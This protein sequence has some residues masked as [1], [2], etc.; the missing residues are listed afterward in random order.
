MITIDGTGLVTG[1][2]G[3]HGLR[4]PGSVVQTLSTTKTDAFSTNSTSFV[5]ITGLSVDITP[6]STSS[7]VL[8]QFVIACGND[9]ATQNRFEL[10]RQVGGSDTS[11]N[12][13]EMDSSTAMFYVDADGSNETYTRAQVAYNFLDSPSTTGQ[14]NYRLRTKIYSSSV[15]QYVNRAAYNSNTIGSSTITVMEIAA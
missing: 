7:K 14:V 5:D 3:G 11:I 15:T 6:T 13:N 2:T 1:G 10:V 8:V 9:A 4:S 12:P